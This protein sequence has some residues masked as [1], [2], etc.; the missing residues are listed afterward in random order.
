MTNHVFAV[1]EE[2]RTARMTRPEVESA[3]SNWLL[4]HEIEFTALIAL[5]GDECEWHMA[6]YGAPE[7]FP[8]GHWIV[9]VEDKL[10]GRVI[11]STI[12]VAVNKASGEAVWYGSLCD[13]G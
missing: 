3:A 13:E 12:A 7:G 1:E 6:P 2:D 11:R 4:E 5:D 9:R 10:T 8:A